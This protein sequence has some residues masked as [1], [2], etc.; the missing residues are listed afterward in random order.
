MKAPSS[1]SCESPLP[2]GAGVP[3]GT[4]GGSFRVKNVSKLSSTP[5]PSSPV[6]VKPV[7]PLP[8]AEIKEHNYSKF[9][10]PLM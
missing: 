4:G 3:E 2:K 7:D 5:K 8:H 10:K 1:D 9:N 6:T